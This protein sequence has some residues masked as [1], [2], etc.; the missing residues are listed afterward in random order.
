MVLVWSTLFL[1]IVF[2]FTN[3]SGNPP[4]G[5]GAVSALTGMI[6]IGT[7]NPL[8]KLHVILPSWT[9]RD[10]A[11]EHVIFGTGATG[12]GIRFGYDTTGN[13]AVVN[14]LKPGG[15][16]GNLVFQDGGGNVGIGT[17]NPGTKLQIVG[18]ARETD[19]VGVSRLWGEG[20]PSVSVMNGGGE[21]TNTVGGDIVKISRSNGNVTWDGAAA[22]CPAG[23]WVCTA[24]ERGVAT[25]NTAGTLLYYWCDIL[26]T[27]D[28]LRDSLQTVL[29]TSGWVANGFS[30]A[31]EK[32]IAVATDGTVNSVNVCSL[33]PAW[34]CSF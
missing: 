7:S 26:S 10:A 15:A 13:K 16:F 14:V 12:D 22:A 1:V 3:P 17:L 6:G 2:A 18:E 34:C 28:E 30:T 11:T 9:S 23:W 21:C 24:A 5:S 4:S 8:G 19:K 29:G 32:G 31:R 33:I 27:T 25:C 20:R